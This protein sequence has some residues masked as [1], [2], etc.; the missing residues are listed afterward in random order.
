MSRPIRAPAAAAGTQGWHHHG[1]RNNAEA[2]FQDSVSSHAC[3]AFA[4]T[5]SAPGAHLPAA[6]AAA[7]G[8]KGLASTAAPAIELRLPEDLAGLGAACASSAT[9]P[10][11][12][13]TPSAA[14]GASRLRS[15]SAAGSDVMTGADPSCA[16]ASARRTPVRGVTNL[17]PVL[18][19]C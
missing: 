14:A 18:R 11:G 7:A 12:S 10:S 15:A 9:A 6:S 8:T 13:D 16:S 3:T 5:T 2:I 17:T 19:L 4:P 1:H